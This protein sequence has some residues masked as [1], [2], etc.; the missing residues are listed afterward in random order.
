MLLGILISCTVATLYAALL[1]TRNRKDELA[2]GWR[3]VLACLRFGFVFFICLLFFFPLVKIKR[4]RIEKP[5]CFLVIDQSSSMR[6]AADT[7]LLERNIRELSQKLASKFEVKTIGLAQDAVLNPGFTFNGTATDYSRAFNLIKQQNADNDLAAVVLFSD[8][9]NNSGQEPV[10]AYR[11]LALPLYTVGLGDTNLYPDLF[12]GQVLTNLYAYKG[13]RFPVHIRIGQHRAP[14][15]Q[16]RLS[17]KTA[18]GTQVLKDTVISFNGQKEQSVAWSIEPQDSGICRYV[19]ALE[20]LANEYD[21]QNNRRAFS[22]RVLEN[23][24]KILILAHAPHPDLSCLRQSLQTQE[25]Y[26]TDVV[27]A[28]DLANFLKNPARLESYDLVVLHGLPSN[29]YP[30]HE[31]KPLLEKKNLFLMLSSSTSWQLLNE[32]DAGIRIQP[33]G[34]RW[35][36]AQAHFN[37]GFSLF[38]VSAQDKALWEKFPPLQTPFALFSPLPGGQSLFTQSILQVPTSDPLL[39]IS[40]P[41]N[42]RTAVCCGTQLWKWRLADFQEKDNTESFDLLL[43]RCLQLLCQAKPESNLNVHCPATWRTTERLTVKAYL[44]N[45]SFEKVENAP[46]RFTLSRKDADY[47]FDFVPENDHYTL[48]AGFL[49]EGEY[50]YEAQATVGDENYRTQGYLSVADPQLENPRQAA[51]H[52]LLHNLALTYRGKFFQAGKTERENAAAW[53]D[54]AQALLQRQDLKPRIK[55]EETYLSPL[56]RTWMLIVLLAFLGFEYFAR[57]RFG[58]L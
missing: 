54:L 36:E 25:K 28:K 39:W 47:A 21:R 10:S 3:L 24:Q 45:A 50:R 46:V 20:P 52:A 22:V 12:I 16:A 49:P 19:L 4:E 55:A 35:N 43:D 7:A 31:L 11:H 26:Q 58:N 9:N 6:G 17:L 42:R 56:N 13:N 2:K 37:P 48:D 34:D 18:N 1:Y 38:N 51:D 41:G 27:L 14:R 53:Q 8:G 30:L 44:Y 29:R 23:R 5:R 57:K 33:R 15:A 40:P 32:M